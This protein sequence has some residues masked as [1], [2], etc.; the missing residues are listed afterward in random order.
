MANQIQLNTQVNMKKKF[1]NNKFSL[2][3]MNYVSNIKKNNL[4]YQLINSFN[5]KKW[6]HYN[7][8]KISII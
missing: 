8:G 5:I 4:K 1:K 7:N 3:D 2:S 6:M